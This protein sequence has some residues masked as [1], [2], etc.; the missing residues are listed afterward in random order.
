MIL[1]PNPVYTPFQP[2]PKLSDGLQTE[3]KLSETLIT[4]ESKLPGTSI[5]SEPEKL[6]ITTV[7]EPPSKTDDK[8]SK[9]TSKDQE[10]ISLPDTGKSILIAVFKLAHLH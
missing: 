7:L 4:F 3:L 5:D 6:E 8:E 10:K 1:T 2:E 9:V